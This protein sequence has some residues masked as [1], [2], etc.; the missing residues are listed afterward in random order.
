M[1]KKDRKIYWAGYY[2]GL[3]SNLSH[4]INLMK[5]QLKGHLKERKK[6]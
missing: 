3:I 1:N 4:N 5:S 6:C 2:D